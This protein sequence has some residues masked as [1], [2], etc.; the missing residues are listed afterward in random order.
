M[1][2]M[3]VSPQLTETQWE[4]LKANEDA[5]TASIIAVNE[6]Q[7][8]A[9]LANAKFIESQVKPFTQRET[10]AIQAMTAM[11]ASGKYG[12]EYAVAQSFVLADKMIAMMEIEE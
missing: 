11:M 7:R 9:I 6:A 1:T 2:V 12:A 10:I 5:K 8:I 4:H 3:T